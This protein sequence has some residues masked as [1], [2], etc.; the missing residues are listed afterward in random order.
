[1]KP[2]GDGQ[3]V[4]ISAPFDAFYRTEFRPVV[5]LALVLSRSPVGAEDLAQEGF[6]AAFR[7]WDRVGRYADPGAWVRRVVANRAVSVWRRRTS[8]LKA[9]TRLGGRPHRSPAQM[10]FAATELWREVRRLPRRQAQAVALFYLEDRSVDNVASILE[11]SVGSVKQHLHRARR[12]LAA[13]LDEE[14]GDHDDR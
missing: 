3:V 12:T 1:M 14:G 7:D 9:L 11:C 8:E 2:H 5:A 10:E 4:G 6:I 13:R